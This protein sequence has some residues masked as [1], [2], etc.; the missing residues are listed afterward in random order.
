MLFAN[1]I[2]ELRESK[3]MLQRHI[4]AAL[5][6][7]NAMYCKIEKGD[8][9]AKREQIPMIAEILQVDPQ[10]LLI[11]WLADKVT[12]VL[13]NEKDLAEKVLKIVTESLIKM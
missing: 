11:L 2:K 10:E 9:R 13:N 7:D 3:Q 6:M 1:K 12:E 4:S 5:D 8:R